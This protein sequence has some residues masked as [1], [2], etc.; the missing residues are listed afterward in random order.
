M[1]IIYTSY[2]EGLTA[3]LNSYWLTEEEVRGITVLF[4]KKRKR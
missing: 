4:W 2:G 1:P 3:P